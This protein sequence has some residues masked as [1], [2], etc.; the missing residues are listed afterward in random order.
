M[1]VG[2]VVGSCTA[3]SHGVRTRGALRVQQNERVGHDMTSV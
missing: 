1:H 3:A 2:R